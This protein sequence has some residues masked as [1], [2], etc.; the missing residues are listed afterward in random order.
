M[1]FDKRLRIQKLHAERVRNI[2]VSRFPNCFAPKGEAK[3][4]LKL[5]IGFDLLLELPEL[6]SYSIGVALDDYC[7]GRRYCE[8]L[9]PG[10]TRFDLYGQEYGIVSAL[11]SEHGK[12]RVEA[13][14]RES[15]KHAQES[16]PVS[17]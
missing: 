4:P 16:Q 11:E 6:S 15:E 17:P 8:S 14:Q 13:W 3:R 5:G 12:R 9:I 2:L 1:Q 7:G 10:E